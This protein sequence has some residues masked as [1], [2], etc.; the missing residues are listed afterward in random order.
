MHE[1][2]GGRDGTRSAT[3]PKMHLPYKGWALRK[4]VF[5]EY[6]LLISRVWAGF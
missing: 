1:K 6:V 5:I 2:Q 3:V 4:F